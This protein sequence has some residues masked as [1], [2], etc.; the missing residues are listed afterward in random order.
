MKPLVRRF[1]LFLIAALLPAGSLQAEDWQG[2]VI[3]ATTGKPIAGATVTVD[4]QT[5]IT[6]A[7]GQYRLSGATPPK[8]RAPGYAREQIA[9]GQDAQHIKLTPLQPK[10]LYLTVYG[11]GAPFLRD[12]ALDVIA[13]TGLNALVID[14]K[15]DRGFIPYPSDLPLATKSGA[16]KL[17][18]IP[19]LKALVADLKARGI[20]LIAR[21]VVFKDDPLAS[22]RPDWAVHN[23]AGGVW[24]DREGLAWIDPFRREAWDYTL[25]VAEEAAAAGFDEIQFDYVRFPDA[26]GLVFSQPSNETSRVETITGFLREAKRRLAP[27]NVFLAIDIFGYVCWNRDDTGIGQR[28]EDLATVVDYISPMLYPSSFQFGIPGYRN[29]VAN[30]YEIV[31]LSL[32]E[33]NKRTAGAPARYRPWLQAFTDYAFGGQAFGAEEIAKQARAARDAGSVGWMLWN[34]RNVYSPNDIKPEIS[35]R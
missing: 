13:R 23:A 6:D 2:T 19:D 21:I 30:P 34:P 35:Q 5:V 31:H 29:P 24:K 28:L 17:R 8:A 27:Y 33:A 1:F 7:Q 32:L 25:G 14:L 16:Q 22:V 15:G 20:Y 10:A 9:A 18:T 26:V 3:D 11:I 12:P 4:S